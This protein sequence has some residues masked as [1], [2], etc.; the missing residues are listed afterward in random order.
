MISSS[1]LRHVPTAGIAMLLLASALRANE[2][3]RS[4]SGS[5]TIVER[6]VTT[7]T[8]VL[9]Q[10][11][12]TQIDGTQYTTNAPG[13]PATAVAP[14]AFEDSLRSAMAAWSSTNTPFSFGALSLT[15]SPLSSAV[16]PILGVSTQVQVNPW[17]P[18]GTFGP[19]GGPFAIAITN[20]APDYA[21]RIQNAVVR[22]NMSSLEPTTQQP[23][24]SFLDDLGSGNGAFSGKTVGSTGI[25]GVSNPVILGTPNPTEAF[26][27]LRGVLV[28]ELGHAIGIA[29]A[30]TDGAMTATGSNTPTMFPRAQGEP[31]AGFAEMVDVQGAGGPLQPPIAFDLSVAAMN[32]GV[33][34]VLG[35]SARTLEDDDLQAM[36][37]QY[38]GRK[39]LESLTGIVRGP[40][41][42]PVPGVLVTA[43]NVQS[44][45]AKR[46]GALTRANGDYDL[47][48]LPAGQYVLSVE[49]VDKQVYFPAETDWPNLI[50]SAAMGGCFPNT[51]ASIV[52]DYWNTA[53]ALNEL[54]Q[55]ATPITLPLASATS[56][57]FI[58]ADTGNLGPEI[59]LTTNGRSSKR[60]TAVRASSTSPITLG[61]GDTNSP[62]APFLVYVDVARA[63]PMGSN[64]QLA[65]IQGQ[66]F[67]LAGGS[68]FN[69]TLDPYG[70]ASIPITLSPSMAFENYMLQ[71]VVIRGSELRVSNLTNLWVAQR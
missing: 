11:V 29:H 4:C 32:T 49:S 37:D 6:W 47:Q 39:A 58:V 61:I 19:A 62:N 35:R 43:A 16:V 46:Y 56:Y 20:V 60:G 44:P 42:A 7:P 64:G 12:V 54:S 67:E 3:E 52:R 66:V 65:L 13:Y 17:E 50:Q 45:D 27:D 24:F 18:S 26:L 68:Y 22:L 57:D 28:H 5:N 38:A 15:S 30:L 14:Y 71:A 59:E 23:W 31:L 48:N 36:N 25:T 2:S 55:V 33:G 53:D 41:G 70:N 51:P 10:A 69:G 63:L 8:V 21:G 34:G 1:S 40:T 9:H